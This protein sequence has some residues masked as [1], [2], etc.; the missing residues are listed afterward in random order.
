[1]NVVEVFNRRDKMVL[2]QCFIIIVA[3][4]FS[5]AT[6]CTY[7]NAY[8]YNARRDE[9]GEFTA[10]FCRSGIIDTVVIANTTEGFSCH[11]KSSCI[12]ENFGLYTP[13]TGISIS[14]AATSEIFQYCDWLKNPRLFCL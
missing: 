9:T 14:S 8:V 1:M 4:S 10:K 11:A 3:F 13:R 6:T 5:S 7:G 2:K 12:G